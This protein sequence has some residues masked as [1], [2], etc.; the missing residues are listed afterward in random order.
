MGE[1]K[2]RRTV[3]QDITA[4]ERESRARGDF[5]AKSGFQSLP[6]ALCDKGVVLIREKNLCFQSD[7]TRQSHHLSLSCPSP[8]RPRGPAPALSQ[9]LYLQALSAY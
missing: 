5:V 3:D 8:L 1:K 7:T 6:M 2:V 9:P 4:K